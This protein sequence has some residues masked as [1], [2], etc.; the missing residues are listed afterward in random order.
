VLWV[1]VC[2][3]FIT[4][5]RAL[6]TWFGATHQRGT[7]DIDVMSGSPL[8]RA[9]LTGLITVA[10]A[11]LINRRE[12]LGKILRRNLWILGLLA[13]VFASALWAYFPEVSNRRA[14]RCAGTLLMVLVVL[15]EKDPIASIIV[16]LRRCYTV[17]LLLSVFTIRYVRDIGVS[18]SYDGMQEEWTGLAMHKNNLGQVAMSSGLFLSWRLMTVT[19]SSA[20]KIGDAVLLMTSL[21]LLRG[22]GT[23]HSMTS[24][25]GFATGVGVLITLICFKDNVK[26]FGRYATLLAVLIGAIGITSYVIFELVGERPVEFVLGAAGRDDTL[27]GRTGLWSD[28]MANAAKHTL[29]GVGY[30][31]FW[32]G[33]AGYEL[34]P[35]PNWS[36]VTPGW[37]P[38]QGHNGYLDVYVEL[39]LLGLALLLAVVI[40]ALRSTHQTLCADFPAGCLRLTFLVAIL[41]NNL[42][43]SSLLRGTHSLWFLFLLF[44][45]AGPPVTGRGALSETLVF[46]R[47]ATRVSP[48]HPRPIPQAR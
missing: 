35:L 28:L 14:I 30:G 8:D 18:W 16:L 47:H 39:G 41:L 46:N 26:Q 40:A 10:G 23:S 34:F 25:A 33:P 38:L 37:R 21:Y 32:V 1:P 29:F 48:R 44:A 6:S 7:A 24:I 12:V 11:V 43:E 15:T 22:S 3:Y 2:W 42:T 27:T 19:G 20:A 36:S 5:T 45:L 17:H 9:V 13:Y 31:S 4:T